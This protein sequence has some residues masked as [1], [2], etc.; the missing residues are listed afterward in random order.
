MNSRSA[1]LE[2]TKIKVSYKNGGEFVEILKEA[3]FTL[4]NGEIVALVA[5][6]GTG[7]S[8]FLHVAGLL[9][10]PISGTIQINNKDTSKL[11]DKERTFIRLN[12]LG[13]VYQSHHL[14]PEFSALE[15]VALPQ[16]IKKTPKKIA[17]AKAAEWLKKFHLNHRL[18]HSPGKLS[19]GEKQRV[20]IARA[21]VN[22]PYILLA[23]EPTGNL[24]EKTSDEVFDLLM[25]VVRNENLSALIVTH[26]QALAAK[27]DR[28]V[29]LKEG[30]IVPIYP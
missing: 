1:I 28:V 10:K 24:D 13:F 5:P 18:T 12:H 23:D 26:N 6:S 11:S 25:H 7:K 20:A 4:Y 8:T 22:T 14:L 17:L 16:L 15:N 2:L 3:D 30:K 29:T 27:M 9:E 21:L 19:G